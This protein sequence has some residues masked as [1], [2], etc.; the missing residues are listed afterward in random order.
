MGVLRAIERLGAARALG[1]EERRAGREP[2][3]GSALEL[4]QKAAQALAQIERQRIEV[5]KKAIGIDVELRRDQDE[6]QRDAAPAQLLREVVDRV[7]RVASIAAGASG[8]ASG[9]LGRPASARFR[10]APTADR[11]RLAAALD[12][13]A[14]GESQ[15][16]LRRR[17][18][19]AFGARSC[20][21]PVAKALVESDRIFRRGRAAG[22]RAGGG[23]GGEERQQQPGGA[24]AIHIPPPRGHLSILPNP[25]P[26]DPARAGLAD[27]PALL[28]AA[29]RRALRKG[30]HRMPYLRLTAAMLSGRLQM[31]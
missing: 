27:S 7:D 5:G 18:P 12:L 19:L 1:A 23:A 9:P 26:G 2:R 4:G 17:A 20:L 31:R 15:P 3:S 29:H 21:H 6:E 14:H 22:G 24:A 8:L 16:S 30:A 13:R 28:T 11:D 25:C 10:A